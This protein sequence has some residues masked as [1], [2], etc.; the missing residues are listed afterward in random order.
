MTTLNT[1]NN[2]WISVLLC[3]YNDEKYIREAVASILDQ[4]YPY[5]EFIIVDDGSTDCTNKILKEFFDPRIILIEKKN[6][7]LTDSLNIG[8]SHCKYDWVARMDGDDISYSDRFEKQVKLIRHDI[9]VIGGQCTYI[10]S[11][12]KKIRKSK[13]EI[14]HKEILNNSLNGYT[15]HIHPTVLINKKL[16]FKVGGYDKYIYAAEDLDLWLSI[17]HYGQLMNLKDELIYYRIHDQKISS[18]KRK[19][20]FFNCQIALLKYK[21]KVYRCLTLNEYTEM[22][23][24]VEK[25]FIYKLGLFFNLKSVYKKGIS[26]RLYN[27]IVLF[28][29]KIMRYSIK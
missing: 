24:V 21:R 25:S 17:S 22:G 3:T 18:T 20:Q 14:T 23:K 2:V 6:T 28:F 7:G 1:N 10:D 19:E 27:F 11:E 5:F 26:R 29:S 12:G 4:T 8:F 13:L 15:A 16:Y 9:A